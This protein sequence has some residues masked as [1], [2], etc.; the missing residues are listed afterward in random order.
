MSTVNSDDAT[1][2]LNSLRYLQMSLG[3]IVYSVFLM[4]DTSAEKN[5][6]RLLSVII[7]CSTSMTALRN[8]QIVTYISATGL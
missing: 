5:I 8:V 2:E 7:I 3:N 6:T 4:N 1:V